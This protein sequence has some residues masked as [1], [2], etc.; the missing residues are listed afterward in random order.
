MAGD[1]I[2]VEH[3][4]PD[5]PEVDQLAA[6]LGIDHDAVV[7]KLLRFW[8][9][10][11]AQSIDGNALAVTPSF[12]DRLTNCP[13]FATGL[14]DVGW[15]ISRNGRFS[16]PNFDRHNGQ[17]AKSRALTKDRVKRSRNDHSVTKAHPEKRREE[18]SIV[19]ASA[20]TNPCKSPSGVYHPSFEIWWKA[21]PRR[22]QK[23]NAYKAW[24]A[25]GKTL[26]NGCG[27]SVTDAVARL[28]DAATAFAASPKGK[29]Q[30]VP[31]PATWLN[32]ACYDDDRATWQD[33]GNAA[34]KPKQRV[35][36]PSELANWNPTTGGLEGG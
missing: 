6:K 36:T 21:Y 12:L 9:W 27:L 24:K 4:M 3:A 2:K 19:S 13:G 5:K 18:K 32:R 26:R 8:I 29:G 33:G 7:G 15:L 25:A 22:T 28:L 11:D 23:A 30:F 35:L 10:A 14:L 34:A 20:E 16:V 1:W 31:H 17:T